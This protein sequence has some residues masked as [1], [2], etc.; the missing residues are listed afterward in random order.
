MRKNGRG[1]LKALLGAVAMFAALFSTAAMASEVATVPHGVVVTPDSGP[2]K[3]VRILAYGDASFRV[4]AL[5][6]AGLDL[7]A[8]LMVTAQPSG[9]PAVSR[10]NGYLILKLPRATAEIRLSDGNVRF[11]DAK[12]VLVLTES[13]RGA[14]G[15]SA[16]PGYLSIQQQF[17]R[18]TDE[19]FF[20]LGQHQNRQMNYNGEDVELAQHNMD[21]AV[22]FVVST[23][24]YGL[25]WDNNAISR[26]GNPA[27]YGHVGQSATPGY[28]TIQQQFNRGTDE[29]FFGLG[30]HQ[31][32][33]MNYNGEDV[34]LAQHNMDIAVPFL[35]S[36]RNYGLLWD[37]NSITRFG[38]PTPY[39][40]VG[41]KLK[42]TSG[43]TPGWK[44]EYYL[45]TKLAVTQQEPVINYEYIRDQDKWP[46]AA[47]AQTVASADSGFT[48][49]PVC[50]STTRLVAATSSASELSGFCT[51]T[52][53]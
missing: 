44:A 9:E 41:T 17:N 51:A 5:P 6:G 4:T 49:V 37:N 7:P 14:F 32:R 22:P 42:V 21:I 25:L 29:G 50:A 10:A 11:R 46:A 15:Q 19:G 36:T 38:N 20:G 12:G 8:S 45:G 35:V 53:L 34:E 48:A 31:N 26:F 27:P 52:T 30:Q 33:Q 28:L 39:A 2:A 23:R 13:A 43:G 24:N 47:K 1:D 3:R 18:G 40:F 16:T